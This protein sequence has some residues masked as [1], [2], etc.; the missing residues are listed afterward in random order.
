MVVDECGPLEL[1]G[2]GLWQPLSRLWHG[3]PGELLVTV[4]ESLLDSL[5]EALGTDRQTAERPAADPK[6]PHEPSIEIIR[7]P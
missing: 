7:L 5:L 4:R 3:F 6:P 2:R 1:E